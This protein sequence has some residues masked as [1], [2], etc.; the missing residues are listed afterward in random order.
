MQYQIP[1]EKSKNTIY[2]DSLQ[3]QMPEKDN[4]SHFQMNER[5]EGVSAEISHIVN[6]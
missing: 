2:E 3:T 6:E 4:M 5:E 1:K